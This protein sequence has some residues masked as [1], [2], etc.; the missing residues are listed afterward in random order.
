MKKKLTLIL[1]LISFGIM[2]AQNE[3][4]HREPFLLKLAV[5]SVNYY[6]QDIKKSP[7]FVK[8]HILQIYPSEKINIQVEIENDSILSMKTVKEIEF[9][10]KTI[11]IN[12]EQKIKERKSEMMMLT[13]KNPFNKI[14]TYKAHMA[15]IGEKKWIPTSI[16]PIQP[17][18]SNFEIWNDVII[19]LI[20]D[21]W[22]L[23]TK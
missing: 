9:P 20:M 7:Y 8:D 15:I 3:K 11:I 19:T 17:K 23:T 1:I 6:K 12:F 16:V 4:S 5:D 21:N 2:H 14:L 10:E 18:L 13:V 22:K